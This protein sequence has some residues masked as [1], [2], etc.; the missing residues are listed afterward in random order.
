MRKNYSYKQPY[1]ATDIDAEVAAD[2]QTL[3]EK[4]E[5]DNLVFLKS[6]DDFA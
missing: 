6:L 2:V 5:P 3:R 4:M 1:I